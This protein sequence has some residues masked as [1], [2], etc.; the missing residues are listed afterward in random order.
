MNAMLKI[1]ETKVQL[2]SADCTLVRAQGL[3]P[4]LSVELKRHA[5]DDLKK[6]MATLQDAIQNLEAELYQGENGQSRNAKVA[7]TVRL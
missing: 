2:A 6:A 4:N 1:G 7:G 5:M 3:R